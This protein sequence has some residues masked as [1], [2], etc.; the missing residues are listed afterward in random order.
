MT[1]GDDELRRE[2]DRP[3]EY[4]Q[5]ARCKRFFTNLRDFNNHFLP[6]G[7]CPP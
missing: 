7:D 4:I 6:N 5:C 3:Y 1:T 2:P